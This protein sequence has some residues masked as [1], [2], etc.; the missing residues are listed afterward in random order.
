MATVSRS[1]KISGGTTLQSATVARA[2]D[3]ETDMLT[4]FNAHNNHDSGASR[5]TVT[6]ATTLK[7]AGQDITQYLKYRRPCIQ[8]S[9]GTVV[10]ME[11]GLSG[12]SGQAAILF[13]DGT[14]RTDSTSGRINCN[15]AQVASGTQSGLRTGTVANNT[16]YAIYATKSTSNSTDIITVADTVFPTQANF[17]T[18]NTNFGTN[19]WQYLGYVGY[20]DN[21]GAASAIMKFVQ[22]GNMTLFYNTLTNNA[23]ANGTG[24]RL[25]SSASA[26]SATWTYAAGSNIATPSVPNTLT[27]AYYGYACTSL[28]AALTVQMA[29]FNAL[30]YT[31]TSG[32]TNQGRFW[33]PIAQTTA[34]SLGAS[35]GLDLFLAGFVD[36]A[37]GVG[38]NPLL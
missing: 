22:A 33:G 17:A 2:A 5:W 35:T 37:L 14:Y 30:S 24:A 32:T 21:S 6:D 1:T 3:V 38:V 29:G 9:S 8:Y 27:H 28:A 31:A 36:G 34:L 20:G 11:T 12:T 10:N 13:P 18:L 25:A 16:W 19:G 15:L 26:S 4:L 7:I 23:G